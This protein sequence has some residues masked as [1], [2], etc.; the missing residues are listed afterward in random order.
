V[1]IGPGLNLLQEDNP[2]LIGSEIARWLSTLEL[3]TSTR[4]YKK[5]GSAAAPFTMSDSVAGDF[6]PDPLLASGAFISSAG[7][8]TL[9]SSAKRRPIQGGIGISGSGESVRIGMANGTDQVN[10]QTESKSRKRAAPGDNWLPPG[11]RVED[12][13]RTSGATAGSVDKYYYE[14]NTGRK[15]RSRTEVLYYLE[16]GTSKRGTKKAENTYF[17]PDHFEGQGSNR[18]TR[19]ATVP[20]P[21]PPPLDFDFKNPPDKV[22]WSMAN[23]GEEGWIPNIGDVKVQDSVRRDWSTA[24]TFI[25]SRNP[26][27]VSA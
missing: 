23:A 21:P 13:I 24:F 5:A 25:T 1:D 18:V 3:G 17:N 12:K 19:T 7:D 15:F 11:W 14:P 20:P 16:H 26:S 10:H 8:G 4:V 6:P 27:K 22:S 9:D 2:D